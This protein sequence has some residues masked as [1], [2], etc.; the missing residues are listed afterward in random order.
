MT[1]LPTYPAHGARQGWDR[2][3]A[4]DAATLVLA[5]QVSCAASGEPLPLADACHS[6]C[7]ATCGRTSQR[8]GV[9]R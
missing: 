9:T 5:P 2:V 6:T 4:P 7:L 1:G 8:A 3:Y